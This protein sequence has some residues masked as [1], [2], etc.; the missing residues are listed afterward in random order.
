VRNIQ[1]TGPGTYTRFMP[2]IRLTVVLLLTTLATG[3]QP[4]EKKVERW[5]QRQQNTVQVHPSEATFEVPEAWR[6]GK[7]FF[8]LTRNEMR[9]KVGRDWIGTQIANGALQL[10]DC[11]AHISPDN[12][13]WMRVYVVDTTEEDVLKRIREKG[14]KAAGRI[15]NY[16]RGH[17]SV[18][19]TAPAK[20]G[21][22]THVDIPYVLDFG[23]SNGEGY[24]SFY[25]RTAGAKELVIVFGHFA[26]GQLTPPDERQNV[27]KSVV[28]PPSGS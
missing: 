9:T 11:A 16:V 6:S 7:T 15:P 24:V 17:S 26:D 18:F 8:R 21:P 23:D 28:V 2:I 1:P 12:L 3:Q 13:N 14:W 22:W 25:L 5:A 19:Q 4:S 27:L 10:D 20:D